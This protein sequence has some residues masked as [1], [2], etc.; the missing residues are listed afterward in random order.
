MNQQLNGLEKSRHAIERMQ[1]RG[2][3]PTTLEL[4]SHFGRRVYDH[5]GACR[6]V[7]DRKA[8]ERVMREYGKALAQFNFNTY[9]VVTCDGPSLVITAGHR[10]R[11]V[12]EYC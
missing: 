10:T 3:P 8:R 11:R 5:R 1:Q 4:L 7:F 9:A 12:R 2:I 6:L